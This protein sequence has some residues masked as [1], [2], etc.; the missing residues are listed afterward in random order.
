MTDPDDTSSRGRIDLSALD[1]APDRG[2]EDAVVQRVMN[3]IRLASTETDIIPIA[4]FQWGMAAAA[5]LLLMLASALVLATDR[6]APDDEVANLMMGW[7]ES[8]HVPTNG[9]LLATYG[10]YRP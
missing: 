10:G 9:E 7:V 2:R 3:R 1:V 5:A 8:G 6:P 4:R